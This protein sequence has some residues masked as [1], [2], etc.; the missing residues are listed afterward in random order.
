MATLA[1]ITHKIVRSPGDPRVE[2]SGRSSLTPYD[3]L[4]LGLGWFGLGLG[5][6]ELVAPGRLAKAI[7]LEG[8][9]GLIRAYGLR[10]I[11]AGVP[12]LSYDKQVGLVS[13]LIGDVIDLATLAPALRRGSA[14]RRKAV[15][16]IAAVAG[17]TVLDIVAT[18]GTIA[19]QRRST[20]QPRDFSDRNGLP[21]GLQASR[22]LARKD[23]VEPADMRSESTN[24]APE[25]FDR[26]I[27]P[28]ADQ[29]AG[30]SGRHGMAGESNSAE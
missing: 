27:G 8:K 4:A 15:M 18:V 17:V 1:N 20:G 14:K 3:R 30:S 12:T 21:Q 23:F 19:R 29:V 28:G 10:E 5:A 9:E 7:G 26:T 13:R 16:A 25:T 24:R 2:R 22:G 11:A 6:A